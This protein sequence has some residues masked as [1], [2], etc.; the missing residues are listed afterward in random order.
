MKGRQSYI[1]MYPRVKALPGSAGSASVRRVLPSVCA[2]PG[3]FAASGFPTTVHFL[4]KARY[5][6]R[7]HSAVKIELL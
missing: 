3:N 5:P 1:R 4:P 6:Q 7:L 2:G